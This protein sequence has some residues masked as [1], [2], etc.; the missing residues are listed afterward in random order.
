[1]HHSGSDRG[2]SHNSDGN[3][4]GGRSTS[5]N[6]FKRASSSDARSL[7]PETLGY[8]DLSSLPKYLRDAFRGVQ[9]DLSLGLDASKPSESLPT[10]S[11]LRQYNDHPIATGE[12]RQE[13]LLDGSTGSNPLQRRDESAPE[14]GLSSKRNATNNMK[15]AGLET[16]SEGIASRYTTHANTPRSSSRCE[17]DSEPPAPSAEKDPTTTIPSAGK[18][19]NHSKDAHTIASTTSTGNPTKPPLPPRHPNHPVYLP[20]SLPIELL[21]AKKT[22]QSTPVPPLAAT[23]SQVPRQSVA[24]LP[25][26]RIRH[27][28][29]FGQRH[30]QLLLLRH[31]LTAELGRC[32][33]RPRLLLWRAR[34]YEAL[35]YDDLAVGD[36]YVG[37]GVGEG[38]EEDLRVY[39][40]GLREGMGEQSGEGE[41]AAGGDGGESTGNAEDDGD[42]DED[43]WWDRE[44]RMETLKIL[45]RCCSRL[46]CGEAEEV[47]MWVDLLD[48][49]QSCGAEYEEYKAWLLLT[50]DSESDY[51]QDAKLGFSRREIYPWNEHEPDR[52][53][54]ECLQELN[55]KMKE[56]SDCLEV[57]RTVLPTTSTLHTSEQH[58]PGPKTSTPSSSEIQNAQL[59]LFTTRPL[60]PNQPTLNEISLLTAIRPH[61]TSLC[62]ACATDISSFSLHSRYSCPACDIPFCSSE[63]KSLALMHYHVPNVDDEENEEGYPVE[64]SPFCAGRSGRGDVHDLGRAEGSELPEWDLYFLLLVRCVMIGETRGVGPLELEEVRWLWGGFNE[65]PMN[66]GVVGRGGGGKV[67]RSLPFG[68]KHSVILPLRLWTTLLLSLPRSTMPYGRVWLERYDW[69]V[70]QTLYAKFRGVADARLGSWDGM[71]ECA[72][73]AWRWALANHDCASGCEWGEAGEGRRWMAVRREKCWSR[74]EAGDEDG[75]EGFAKGEEVFSHYTDVREEDYKIRRE[76]LQEVLGGNCMCGR[77]VWEEG[78]EEGMEKKCQ[79]MTQGET[80]SR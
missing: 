63:C 41:G 51:V 7:G 78:M 4:T 61:G 16:G 60:S 15:L 10:R 21:S 12:A 57:R 67:K 48:R 75:W 66:A 28:P 54:D 33:P 24:V 20:P 42:E 11:L 46:G 14:D 19:S 26:H 58:L 31:Y 45:I 8:A 49:E 76:R 56:V 44:G 69:W 50:D 18:I 34:C 79:S 35:E 39:L 38:D 3:R 74:N 52:M 25:L 70:V 27:L 71:P 5:R 65:Y 59:G 47:K 73:V 2:V 80:N 6:T 22:S 68:L 62:D 36:A 30:A 72:S 37:L 9:A 13:D 40:D 77:C 55:E 23:T 64:A 1:M 29:S 17:H 32:G 43:E 53:S